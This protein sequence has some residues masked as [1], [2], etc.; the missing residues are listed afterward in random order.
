MITKQG[1]SFS[2]YFPITLQEKKRLKITVV[3][4]TVLVTVL[5]IVSSIYVTG[6]VS[7]SCQQNTTRTSVKSS[8]NAYSKESSSNRN[9]ETNP[10]QLSKSIGD[11]PAEPSPPI[12]GVASNSSSPS[13]INNQEGPKSA[14]NDTAA[15]TMP[16]P[17]GRIYIGG[18]APYAYIPTCSQ[19]PRQLPIVPLTPVD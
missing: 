9:I 6:K 19:K 7:Q 1:Q 14:E 15:G 13:A 3:L 11:M 4:T 10:S 18:E 17:D 2:S 16:P 12:G 5:I 8:G